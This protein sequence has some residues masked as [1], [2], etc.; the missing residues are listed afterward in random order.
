VKNMACIKTKWDKSKQEYIPT[1]VFYNIG[2]SLFAIGDP[3]TMSSRQAESMKKN[4]NTLDMKE[5]AKAIKEIFDNLRP[6]L[7]GYGLEMEVVEYDGAN[8]K[9]VDA[10]YKILDQKPAS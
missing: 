10:M 3:T 4:I 9:K 2:D 5:R 8:K 1:M 6:P 7:D